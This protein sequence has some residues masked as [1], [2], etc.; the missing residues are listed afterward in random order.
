MINQVNNN[1]LNLW[2]DFP[3]PKIFKFSFVIIGLLCW[4]EYFFPGFKFAS[5]YL[6]IL[7]ATK[8]ILMMMISFIA[9]MGCLACGFLWFPSYLWSLIKSIKSN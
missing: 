6:S 9:I 8:N 4:V 7:F 1:F 3:G 2:K 5:H